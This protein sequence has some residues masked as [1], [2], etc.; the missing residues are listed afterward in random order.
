MKQEIPGLDLTVVAGG[1]MLPVT[2]PDLVADFIRR[3]ARLKSVKAGA[4]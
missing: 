4:T 2:Q 3:M 1:H